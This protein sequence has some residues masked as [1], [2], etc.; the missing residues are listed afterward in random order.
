M[1]T[2]EWLSLSR[3]ARPLAVSLAAITIA[4]YVVVH[5]LAGLTLPVPWND[6]SW[7]LWKALALAERGTLLTEQMNPDRQT[8]CFPAYEFLHAAI[9]RLFGL[10]LPTARWVSACSVVC[11]YVLLVAVLVSRATRPFFSTLLLSAFL[12]GASL[13]VC[14]NLVRPESLVLLLAVMSSVL[15]AMT[16]PV[17]AAALVALAPLVHLNGCYFA[18]ALGGAAL[19]QWLLGGHRLYRMEAICLFYAL[20]GWLTFILY[21]VPQREILL[22]DIVLSVSMRTGERY[23][24]DR[25]S[26]S[27][28]LMGLV[29]VL[30]LKRQPW[31]AA[32]AFLSMGCQVA[33]GRAAS[34]WYLSYL[35]VGTA[36]TCVVSLETASLLLR[37]FRDGLPGRWL[38]LFSGVAS[39]AY[40]MSCLLLAWRTERL[41]GP[42]NYVSDLHFPG[43]MGMARGIEYVTAEDL[44][45][46]SRRVLD[47]AGTN[48]GCRVM[49]GSDGDGLLFL[50][51]LQGRVMIYMPAMT[52][53]PPDIV[54]IHLSRYLPSWWLSFFLEPRMRLYEIGEEDVVLRRDG[55]EAWY[56]KD[57]RAY[58]G[59]ER[60]AVE[61]PLEVF[62]FRYRDLLGD[63][64]SGGS[65]SH[66]KPNS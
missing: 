38:R 8:F 17:G 39:A 37:A 40:F 5:R 54:V 19:A 33:V 46:V 9:I 13:V 58:H 15:L 27:A 7:I 61:W 64:A 66:N 45:L 28:L 41:P 60:G 50:S 59:T 57:V 32:L 22:S 16:R 52:Q 24:S 48:T 42:R 55:T 30:T 12:F 47:M 6:E 4:G 29:G 34:S 62:G 21:F 31:L 2:K 18:L 25:F 63:G 11:S 26:V 44:D 51:R 1:V 23:V 56:V 35:Q 10:A 43:G 36:L 53:T 3:F 49:F 65:L 20:I 14:G